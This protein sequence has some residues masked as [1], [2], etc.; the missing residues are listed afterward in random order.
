MTPNKILWLA[1][2]ALIF[3]SLA[4]D[5][6]VFHRRAKTASFRQSLAWVLIWFMLAMLF[7]A[8]VWWHRGPE[9]A[10]Q[11][12]T[13]YVIEISLSMDNVF[14]FVSI[15]AFFAVPAAYQ[16]KILFWG[17]LGAMI[18]RGLMIG[19]GCALVAKFAWILYIFGGFLILTGIKMALKSAEP[20]GPER[21]PV[22][23]LVRKVV[24]MADGYRGSNFFVRENGRLLATPIFLVLV[25]V[26]ASDVVFAVDSVPAIFAITTDP[27]IVFTSNIFAILG[28]RSLYFVLAAAMDKFHLLHY[29]LGAVLVFV[30][31]K[32][33]LDHTRFEVGTLASLVVVG[34]ILAVSVIASLLRP[35]R[36]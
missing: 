15:F 13:G 10:L 29:G 19:L 22:V 7:N 31:T 5:L 28:L 32:M 26:E 2:A 3:C 16:H 33:L 24:P 27:F 21:N 9:Q 23:R 12:F 4:A 17:I 1:F 20:V 36:E 34:A 25:L 8:G 35:P 30:G 18:L 11:F 14:V 6:G